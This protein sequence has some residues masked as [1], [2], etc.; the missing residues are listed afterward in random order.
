M[1]ETSEPSTR[2]GFKRLDIDWVA[3]GV[4]QTRLCRKTRTPWSVMNS[5]AFSF[6]RLGKQPLKQITQSHRISLGI[7]IEALVCSALSPE[8]RRDVDC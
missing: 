8:P 2:V 6:L 1:V 3:D 4:L 7:S 5:E